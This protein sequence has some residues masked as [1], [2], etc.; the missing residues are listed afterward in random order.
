MKIAEVLHIN[1]NCALLLRGKLL[2]YSDLIIILERNF[3]QTW[4]EINLS[5]LSVYFSGN[6]TSCAMMIVIR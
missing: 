4:T 1:S 3:R 6:S 2:T 5:I